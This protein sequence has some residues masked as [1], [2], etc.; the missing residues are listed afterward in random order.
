MRLRSTAV[1]LVLF[2]LAAPTSGVLAQAPRHTQAAAQVATVSARRWLPDASLRAGMR[3]LHVEVDAL[4]HA[5]SSHMSASMIRDHAAAIERAVSEM[6]AQ[7]RLE[8]APDEALH[9]ILV[10]LLSAAQSL[11]AHPD[12]LEAVAKMRAAI[13]SYPRYFDDPGWDAAAAPHAMH[14][15][16]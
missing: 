5:E 14:D 4:Q 16:P 7:C 3:K 2:C 11:K 9:G 12:K 6:F 13:A 10:P 8:P 1:S 15:E